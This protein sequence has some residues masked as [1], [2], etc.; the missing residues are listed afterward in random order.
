MLQN[1]S[2]TVEAGETLGIVGPSGAG[3]STLLSLVARFYDPTHGRVMI[4]GED[5]R[6]LRLNDIYKK[7]AIVT[8]DS[9]RHRLHRI[10]V[11][12]GRLWFENASSHSHRHVNRHTPELVYVPLRLQVFRKHERLEPRAR[13]AR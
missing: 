10:G 9:N 12:C 8:Q 11:I 5:L 3:K 7:V 2:L 4:D 6:D 13:T 1:V